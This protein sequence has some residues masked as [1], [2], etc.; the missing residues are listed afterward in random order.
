MPDEVVHGVENTGIGFHIIEEAH[1]VLLNLFIIIAGGDKDGF[2]SQPVFAHRLRNAVKSAFD[3]HH[4]SK[5]GGNTK[6]AIEI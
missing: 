4:A 6:I 1:D 2:A 5:L 3:R